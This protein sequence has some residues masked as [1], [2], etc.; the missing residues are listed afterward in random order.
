[1][2][3][4]TQMSRHVIDVRLHDGPHGPFFIGNLQFP[5]SMDTNDVIVKVI[6][7]DE[8]EEDSALM[9]E[10]K[11]L[12]AKYEGDFR[13]SVELEPRRKRRRKPNGNGYKVRDTTSPAS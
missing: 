2:K 4:T 9:R 10:L 6:P 8:G 7:E 1:M 11:E 13:W 12:L 5:G 3:E